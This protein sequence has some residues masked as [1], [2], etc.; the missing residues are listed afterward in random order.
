MACGLA[1]VA[2]NIPGS[3]D[4]LEE[5]DAGVL[6]EPGDVDQVVRRV[7]WLISNRSELQALRLRAYK[8]AQKCSWSDVA[9][10][11]EA[12]YR[13]WLA[14]KSRNAGVRAP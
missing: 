4:I 2:T 14:R 7:D 9:S 13:Q 12:M 5:D 11:T 10:E 3:R 8:A 6:V 1:V